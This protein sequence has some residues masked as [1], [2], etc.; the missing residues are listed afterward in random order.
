M[1]AWMVSWCF[2][3]VDGAEVEDGQE[4]FDQGGRGVGHD[5][6]QGGQPI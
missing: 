2:A 5:V 1:V 4:F 3:V 6:A